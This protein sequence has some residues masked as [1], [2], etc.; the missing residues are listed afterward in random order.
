[1]KCKDE[2][3]AGKLQKFKKSTKTNFPTGYPGATTL[4]PI[5]DSFKHIEMSSNISGPNV[6]V[7]FERTDVI[8]IS[9]ITF[10]YKRFS[11]PAS[12]PGAM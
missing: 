9:K 7:S 4:P 10:Y 11:N 6:A 3:D 2:N 5:G 12:S 8:Q 1:M